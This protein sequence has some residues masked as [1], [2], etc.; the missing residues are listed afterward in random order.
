MP[1]LADFDAEVK[2][3]GVVVPLTVVVVGKLSFDLILGTDFFREA[4]A[5]VDVHTNMLSPFDGLT[6]VPMTATGEPPVVSTDRL[7][8][9]PPM[10]EAV[11]P[12][13]TSVQL[14]RLDYVIGGD[15]QLP[16]RALLVARTLIK[17]ARGTLLCRVMNPSTDPTKLKPRTTVGTITA[18]RAEPVKKIGCPTPGALPSVAEMRTALDAKGISL[19]DTAIEGADLEGLISLLNGYVI[20]RITRP[21]HNVPTRMHG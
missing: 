18:V 20:G 3:G 2:V 11:F 6:D 14:E 7:V 1:I 9:I 21:R 16:C 15:L 4:R 17:G 10:S 13:V 8:I 5:I 19:K 12:V